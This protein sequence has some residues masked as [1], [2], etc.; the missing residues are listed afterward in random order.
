MVTRTLAFLQPTANGLDFRYGVNLADWWHVDV[1]R[2]SD[3]HLSVENIL[4][5]EEAPLYDRKASL[6]TRIMTLRIAFLCS[7]GGGNLRFIAQAIEQRTL[8]DAMI[9]AVLTDRECLANQFAREHRIS[10]RVLDFRAQEQQEVLDALGEAT[11]DVVVTNVHKIL[12]APV[13]AAYRGR[14]VNLH[15]SLLPAYG[16]VIGM[17]PV[18]LALADGV[19][20]IGVTAHH[21]DEAVDAGKPIVQAVIPTE[22]HD[23]VASLADTVFRNGCLTLLEALR[24]FILASTDHTGGIKNAYVR[25]RESCFNP[26]L[27]FPASLFDEPFWRKLADYPSA[28]SARRGHSAQR[29]QGQG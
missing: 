14:L 28:P 11:A 8:P 10:T 16:G 26:G 13:V 21:V 9:C 15:Y 5:D 17:R 7:G 19:K 4:R 22:P 6:S 2:G 3:R 18:E 1:V 29:I 25:N 24:T 12:A 27:S 23:T 20:F